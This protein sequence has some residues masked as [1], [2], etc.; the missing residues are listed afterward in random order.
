MSLKCYIVNKFGSSHWHSSWLKFGPTLRKA[1]VELLVTTRECGF[2]HTRSHCWWH[3]KPWL[4]TH[5]WNKLCNFIDYK[6]QY[7][8]FIVMYIILNDNLTSDN[9]TYYINTPF[10]DVIYVTINVT[11]FTSIYEE[12]L[13]V[14]FVFFCLSC[15]DLP[16]HNTSCH[17]LGTIGKPLMS[18]PNCFHNVLTYDG[19]VI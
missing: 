9:D 7:M 3:K 19:E 14:C 16:N 12:R 10:K 5:S 13:F 4:M 11:Y 2:S 8:M 15:G 17:I 6:V 18:A 1:W